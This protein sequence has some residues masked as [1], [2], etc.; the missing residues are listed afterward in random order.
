MLYLA[1]R[2]P[3]VAIR[4]LE[5]EHHK[6]EIKRGK[7]NR[8]IS[9]WNESIWSHIKSCPYKLR[10]S[11]FSSIVYKLTIFQWKPVHCTP[12]HLGNPIWPLEASTNF[13]IHLVICVVFALSILLLSMATRVRKDF[14]SLTMSLRRMRGRPP[15]VE[16]TWERVV[17]SLKLRI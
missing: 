15:G 1:K 12:N 5:T 16:P 10:F 13:E 14:Y 17:L 4:H 7:W 11:N 8:M 9:Y 2:Q 3:P 6:V